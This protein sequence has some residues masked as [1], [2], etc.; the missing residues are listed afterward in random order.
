MD[1]VLTIAPCAAFNRW[2][3]APQRRI[4]PL[5]LM[6]TTSAKTS[7]SCSASRRMT[8]AQLTRMSSRG[9]GVVA[10]DNPRRKRAVEA[11][12]CAGRVHVAHVVA[13]HRFTTVAIG[14][15][16]ALR[17]A[18]QHDHRRARFVTGRND[19]VVVA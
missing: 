17:A 2:R 3:A 9:K 7:A 18:F 13:R 5:R 15:D 19:R 14:Y 16:A 11:I 12:A 1:A 4:V 6:S 10:R 8:P